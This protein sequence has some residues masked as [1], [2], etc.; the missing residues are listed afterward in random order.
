[1]KRRCSRI[2]CCCDAHALHFSTASARW[3]AT[4]VGTA[5]HEV[6]IFFTDWRLPLPGCIACRQNIRRRVSKQRGRH[7]CSAALCDGRRANGRHATLWARTGHVTTSRS[8]FRHHVRAAASSIVQTPLARPS[9]EHGA[10]RR[11]RRR[12]RRACLH[13][14]NYI[15]RD[16]MMERS[17]IG[18]GN[19]HGRAGRQR[20]VS[21]QRQRCVSEREVRAAM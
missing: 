7:A 16:K 17:R 13:D 3:H 4:Q 1:M 9:R 6:G 20:L 2:S 14:T 11:R 10:A 5:R 12:R 18:G 8:L 15:V 19:M 21:S